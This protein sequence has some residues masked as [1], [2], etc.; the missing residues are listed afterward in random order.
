VHIVATLLDGRPA[1]RRLVV[2]SGEA[3]AAASSSE[4]LEACL[5]SCLRVMAPCRTC[6]FAAVMDGITLDEDDDDD[7]DDEEE[8]VVDD[9][10]Y[11]ESLLESLVRSL[12]APAVQLVLASISAHRQPS[13]RWGLAALRCC[14]MAAPMCLQPHVRAAMEWALSGSSSSSSSSSTTTTTTTGDGSAVKCEAIIL[15]GSLVEQY[16]EIRNEYGAR[17]LTSFH[18]TLIEALPL[19]ETAQPTSVSHVSAVCIVTCR[20]LVSFCRG[21]REGADREA[22]DPQLVLPHLSS[23]LPAL[24]LLLQQ[25]AT[26]IG[27]RA[28]IVSAVACLAT[29]AGADFRGYYASVMPA[30]LRA[31]VSP[32]HLSDASPHSA[33][34]ISELRGA[35]LE[36]ATVVGQAIDDVGLF[37][38][39]ATQ[40]LQFATDQLQQSKQ[41]KDSYI[42][43]EALLSACA[44]VRVPVE[45]IGAAIRMAVP[46]RF[47]FVIRSSMLRLLR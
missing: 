40:L 5:A 43:R 14:A 4:L 22:V 34:A 3:A 29:V 17:I 13:S 33:F 1:L 32:Y 7:D 26:R 35:S 44:R 18:A 31:I 37:K 38:G 10:L 15:L 6:S 21:T 2:G 24:V 45:G 36:S 27:V 30:L 23:L 20:A 9:A 28:S 47:D 41:M 11:A 19:M 25:P 46:S 39:D 8:D 16:P 42:P 12:G